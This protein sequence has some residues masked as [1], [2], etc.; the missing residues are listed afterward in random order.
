MA[1]SLTDTDIPLPPLCIIIGFYPDI[2]CDAMMSLVM[3]DVR[4]VNSS[5]WC[6]RV[7]S[8]FKRLFIVFSVFHIPVTARLDL[9]N[10]IGSRQAGLHWA[11]L[12]STQIQIY[13]SQ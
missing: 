10:I 5:V 7:I 9:E 11:P 2:H 12:G 1:K 13:Y 6:E 4:D 3:T 8:L